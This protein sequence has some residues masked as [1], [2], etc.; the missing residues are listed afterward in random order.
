MTLA[1]LARIEQPTMAATLT[2]MARDGLI[3][4]RPDPADK[5]SSLIRLTPA[6]LEHTP[7]ILTTMMAAREELLAGFDSAEREQLV[8]LLHRIV[9]NLEVA[10]QQ[11]DAMGEV[12]SKASPG[13]NEPGS[14]QF[15][16]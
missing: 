6:A 1:R 15:V 3:V 10:D 11:T 13:V 4:R 2:R 5:R 16:E 8:A 9:T 12:G 7:H 14:D